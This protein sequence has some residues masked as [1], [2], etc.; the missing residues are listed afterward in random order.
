MKNKLLA[1]AILLISNSALA[2]PTVFG[3]SVNKTN[4]Q[5]LKSQYSVSYT[6]INK[7]SGGDMYEISKGQIEFDGLKKVTT[8]FSEEGILLAVLAEFP[9]HKFDYLNSFLSGKYSLVRKNI[10]FVG[11]KS[12]TYR[13]GSTE[14]E[15]TAPHMSF[16]MSLNYIHDDLLSVFNQQSEK[17]KKSKQKKESSML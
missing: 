13:D 16:E 7:Y 3:L 15:L 11:N 2:N 5:E 6:G 10:P 1:F 12:A 17:E 14:I 9:K 8:I 4:V